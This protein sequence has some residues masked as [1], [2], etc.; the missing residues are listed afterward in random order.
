MNSMEKPG[1]SSDLEHS[2]DELLILQKRLEHM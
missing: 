2:E 1:E